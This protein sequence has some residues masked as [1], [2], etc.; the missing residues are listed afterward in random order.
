MSVL[1]TKPFV[2]ERSTRPLTRVEN[3]ILHSE[4]RSNQRAK[5]EAEKQK[6][7]HLLEMENL[8][9]RTLREAKEAKEIAEYRRSLVHKAMPVGHYAPLLIKPSDKPVTEPI[10]PHFETDRVLK[11]KYS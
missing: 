10:S 6:R 11:N 8:Q 9:R 5:F 2:P 3:V 1:Y 4:Q 7:T